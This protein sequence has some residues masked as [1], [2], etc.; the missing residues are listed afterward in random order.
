MKI[1]ADGGKTYE[2]GEFSLGEFRLMKRE[3]GLERMDLLDPRDPDHLVGV[4]A[5]AARRESPGR[6]WE[7]IVAEVERVESIE[8]EGAEDGDED[9][10]ADS[11][12]S[13]KASEQ[14]GSDGGPVASS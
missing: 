3:F 9:P 14:S 12:E 7:E 8:V 5:I 4:L 6:D 11:P 13:S 10:T 1:T 2:V